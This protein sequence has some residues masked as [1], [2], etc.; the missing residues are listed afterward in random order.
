M[1]KKK[2]IFNNLI[3]F[4]LSSYESIYLFMAIIKIM[5]IV[6]IFSFLYIDILSLTKSM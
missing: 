5:V 2:F 4:K 6:F 1:I 3:A